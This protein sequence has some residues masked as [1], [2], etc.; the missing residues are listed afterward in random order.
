MTQPDHHVL[1]AGAGP[2]GLI[3]AAAAARHGDRRPA[4]APHSSSATR[5]TA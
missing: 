1:V 2:A 5:R 3:T 4:S